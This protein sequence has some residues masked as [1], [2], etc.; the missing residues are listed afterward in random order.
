MDAAARALNLKVFSEPGFGLN[1]EACVMGWS[2]IFNCLANPAT[3]RVT[4]NSVRSADLTQLVLRGAG[5]ERL[6]AF[7]Q[8]PEHAFCLE[9]ALRVFQSADNSAPSSSS[10][11]Q[12]VSMKGFALTMVALQ[13]AAEGHGAH[14]C[15]L[16]FRLFNAAGNGRLS[17]DEFG[18]WLSMLL[19]NELCA[20]AFD[21]DAIV[22]RYM[23]FRVY[24]CSCGYLL[25]RVCAFHSWCSAS[26]CFSVRIC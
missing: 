6:V 25:V 5:V 18:Q 12:G 11:L 7:L 14:Q 23:F 3:G 9:G 1:P 24:S 22:D 8:S 10:Q 19:D 2:K 16:L 4:A 13:S 26:N 15:E 20:S 21:A 17:K